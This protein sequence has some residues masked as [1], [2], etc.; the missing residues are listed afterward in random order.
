[1]NAT[2][3][4]E[5]FFVIVY[6]VLDMFILRVWEII[7]G[8]VLF[9]IYLL[10]IV[11]KVSNSFAIVCGRLSLQISPEDGDNQSF[12]CSLALFIRLSFLVKKII[13]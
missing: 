12:S 13:R 5:P 10:Y 6:A 3:F 8:K 1:M 7:N 9:N 2:L 4:I 11:L